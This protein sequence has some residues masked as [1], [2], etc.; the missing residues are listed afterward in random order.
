M[1][2]EQIPI[3]VLP[4]RPFPLYLKDNN[5][6]LKNLKPNQS[7]AERITVNR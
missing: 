4:R 2:R 5:F 3:P 6:K 7:Y 1:N